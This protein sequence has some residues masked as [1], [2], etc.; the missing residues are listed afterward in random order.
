MIYRTL[1]RTGLDVSVLG[2]GTGGLDA[3]GLKSGRSE[4]EMRD[5]LRYAFDL[6]INYFDTSPGY[7][8]GRSERILGR[9]VSEIGRDNVVVSTKI[10]LAGSMPGKPAKVMKPSDVGAAVDESLRRLQMDYVD[11]MLMAAADSPETFDTVITD[12][13]PELVK[14][15]EQGKIRFI[16]SSEQTRS[17]GA[18]IWLQRVLPTDQIDVAMV[19][20][21]MMNQ[22]A[23]RTVFPLCREKN[24]GVLNIFT[25]RNL[26]WNMPRLKEV[27]ADLKERGVIERDAVCDEAPLGW[28]VEYGECESLV[29]AAYRHAAY[30]SGV[31]TVMCGT[32]DRGELEQDTA[33]V[34][35]GPLA[36]E[37]LH[38]L[39]E[40]FG[41]IEEA[42]GN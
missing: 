3:M 14:L 42:I 8:D 5:F 1:G 31:T 18:H 4:A 34:R 29:E 38:R 10:A 6:G 22:S 9:A 13:I 27:I 23:Q 21:N 41:H 12:L 25:V 11:V 16:G 39:H 35:K 32:I 30:T 26:F 15:K 2:M 28:L 24:I 20:H 7:G 17:D 36:E 37:K 40:T 33:F 19:G